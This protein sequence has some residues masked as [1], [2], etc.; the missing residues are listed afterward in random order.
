[1]RFHISLL[2]QYFPDRN[3]SFA[4]FYRQILDQVELAEEL[5]CWEGF[6]F[7]EHHFLL[8][9]GAIPNPA[10]FIA[11]AA[12]R[13][14]RIRLGSCI[15]VLPLR[16]PLH[17]AEDYAMA[18][19]VSNGR[20]EF[21]IGLVN[22]ALDYDVL[23]INRDES[24]GRFEESAE[25]IV[26]AWKNPS[27]SHD[28]RFWQ[29][30]DVEVYPQ[31]VQQP[32]PP[33]W[34]AASSEASLGW[35]GRHGYDVMTVAHPRPPEMVRPGVEAWRRELR[36]AGFDPAQRHVQLAVRVWVDENAERAR[37]TAEAAI[38]RYDALS[39]IKRTPPKGAPQ[40]AGYDWQDMLNCGRNIYGSPEQVVQLIH[41][42]QRHFDFDVLNT[43][44]NFGGL[45]HEDIVAAMRL[46]AR[47]VAPAFV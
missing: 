37:E 21:G 30:D 14:S 11:A 39:R 34:V 43:V 38:S 5:G 8:Y 44:F 4:A 18:D 25:V 41:N 2:P 13:T 47:D 42:A 26:G 1:V 33:V 24:R 23:G 16:H 35:A 40:S 15:S 20:L 3:G 29:F 31:P 19:V 6:W 36:L 7:T 45:Q 12:A 46:F 28:G 27:F 17:V 10:T 22:T 9:G 32:C